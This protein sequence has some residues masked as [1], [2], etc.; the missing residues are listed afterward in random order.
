MTLFIEQSS[1]GIDH[2]QQLP[3]FLSNISHVGVFETQYHP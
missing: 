2:D 3:K 1:Y